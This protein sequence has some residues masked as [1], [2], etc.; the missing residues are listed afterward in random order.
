MRTPGQWACLMSLAMAVSHAAAQPGSLQGIW[1]MDDRGAWEGLEPTA[2]A[3]QAIDAFDRSVDDPSM[4]CLPPGLIRT[5]ENRAPVEFIEQAHQILMVYESFDVLRRIHLDG[6]QAPERLPL[7]PLGYSAGVWEGNEL[8]V[9][10]THLTPMLLYDDGFP[11]SGASDTRI[12]ERYR[13]SGD[14]LELEFTVEDPVNLRG[15]ASRIM[16]FDAAPD[17]LLL[18]FLC[19]P[20]DATGWRLRATGDPLRDLLRWL[21]LRPPIP[22]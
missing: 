7:S 11:F 13:R 17:T 21:D 10:T 14:R 18:H 9:E 6:R 4:R 8:V 16:T 20:L 1:V 3:V 15:P 12:V 2:A 22:R 19:D 5:A